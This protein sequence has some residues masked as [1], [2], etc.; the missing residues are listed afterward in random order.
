LY[1]L[2]AFVRGYGT[3]PCI[4]AIE[5]EGAFSALVP[6]RPFADRNVA[7][8]PSFGYLWKIGR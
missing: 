4:D 2:T 3:S 6:N 1:P 8:L 5:P 7:L